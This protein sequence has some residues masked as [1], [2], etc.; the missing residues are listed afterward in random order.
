[1]HGRMQLVSTITRGEYTD[2]ACNHPVAYTIPTHCVCGIRVY[3]VP[4]IALPAVDAYAV[5]QG[6]HTYGMMSYAWMHHDTHYGYIMQPP[7]LFHYIT[8]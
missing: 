3:A 1:M 8:W 2:L 6:L 5:L 4:A 7:C